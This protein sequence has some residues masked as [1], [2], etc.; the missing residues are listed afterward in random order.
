MA[1]GRGL[2]L[3]GVLTVFEAQTKFVEKATSDIIRLAWY[4]YPA[5]RSSLTQ[6]HAAE[7]DTNEYTY[8]IP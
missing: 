5:Y 7:V 3:T 4:G 1:P 2:S 8:V 6:T